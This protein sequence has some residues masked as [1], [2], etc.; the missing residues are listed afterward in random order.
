MGFNER[1]IMKSLEVYAGTETMDEIKKKFDRMRLIVDVK[2]P[3]N[4]HKI[5]D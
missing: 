2:P 3:R 5:G 4:R 1:R